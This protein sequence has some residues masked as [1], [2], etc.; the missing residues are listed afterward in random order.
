L[1]LVGLT[2]VATRRVANMSK[3]MQQRLG[4]AQ[5]LIGE[6]KL[7]LLD[8]P[9]SA[10]D[11]AGRRAVRSILESLR[12]RGLAVL[13]NSHLLSEIELVCDRVIIL[14]HGRVIAQGA[15]DDLLV[16][17]GVEIETRSGI[18]TWPDARRDE[19]PGLVADL[20]SKGEDIYAVRILRPSLEDFYLEAVEGEVG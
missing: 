20:V 9:T 3:G 6:P 14:Q 17:R 18:K 5:A 16:A 11:P 13:L 4:L 7:L 2:E 15:P 12:D 8:E 1:D 10:L 19:V